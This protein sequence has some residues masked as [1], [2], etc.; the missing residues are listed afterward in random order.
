MVYKI[1]AET[2]NPHIILFPDVYPYAQYD[3]AQ[4][5]N[6]SDRCILRVCKLINSEANPLFPKPIYDIH[7]VR[8]APIDPIYA[9]P[10]VK[11]YEGLTEASQK[12]VNHIRLILPDYMKLCLLKRK[13]RSAGWGDC[14]SAETKLVYVMQDL[15]DYFKHLKVVELEPWSSNMLQRAMNLLERMKTVREVTIVRDVTRE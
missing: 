5:Q 14:N 13:G 6:P 4:A 9:N 12:K 10:L 8:A 7:V 1:L 3:G 15:E 2:S 11:W